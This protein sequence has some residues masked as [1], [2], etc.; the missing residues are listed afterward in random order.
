M[1]GTG[2]GTAVGWIFDRLP[3]KKESLRKVIEQCKRKMN[4]FQKIPNPT[5]SDRRIYER[6]SHKLREAQDAIEKI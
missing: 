6:L 4:E 1:A 2:W 5:D 3:N